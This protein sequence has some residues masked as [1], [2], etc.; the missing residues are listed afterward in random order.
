MQGWRQRAQV[1]EW[2][3][4]TLHTTVRCQGW[5]S[6]SLFCLQLSLRMHPDAAP[7]VAGHS[8]SWQTM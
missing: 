5:D 1:Q 4:H 8:Y 6:T 2:L 3:L 7:A